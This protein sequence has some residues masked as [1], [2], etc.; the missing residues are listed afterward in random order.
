MNKD[1]V[2]LSDIFF[3]NRKKHSPSDTHTQTMHLYLSLLH[4]F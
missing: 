4:I 1:C 3:Y 2:V